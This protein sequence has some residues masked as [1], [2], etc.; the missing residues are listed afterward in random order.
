MV[1]VV[2][3]DPSSCKSGAAGLAHDIYY[4][5]AF[6]RT[7][8]SFL[9]MVLPKVRAVGARG[10]RLLGGISSLPYHPLDNPEVRIEG[11]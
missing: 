9:V 7:G 8:P 6:N 1:L 10:R 11:L 4:P 5:G 2:D 3:M